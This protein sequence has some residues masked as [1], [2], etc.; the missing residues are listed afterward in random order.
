METI[1]YITSRSGIDHTYNAIAIRTGVI[2][3]P[4]TYAVGN[5]YIGI[6]YKMLS[7]RHYKT[8]AQ[9]IQFLETTP[10]FK[11]LKTTPAEMIKD[12]RDLWNQRRNTHAL[13][14]YKRHEHMINEMFNTTMTALQNAMR[15]T[16]LMELAPLRGGKELYV[17]GLDDPN[18]EQ[19]ERDFRISK[20]LSLKLDG[21]DTVGPYVF[22]LVDKLAKLSPEEEDALT[23]LI[24]LPNI[25]L[26]SLDQLLSVRKSLDHAA[27]QLQQL[28]VPDI[29]SSEKP[30]YA[31]G[32]WN[33]AMLTTCGKAIQQLIDGNPDLNWALSIQPSIRVHVLAGEMDI[34]RFWQ[35]QRTNNQM[36]DDTWE[37]LQALPPEEPYPRTVPVF[38]IKFSGLLPADEMIDQDVALTPKRKTISLD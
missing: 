9:K 12:M 32:H 4:A 36:P 37:V 7:E 26:L 38:V 24:T 2:I 14:Q 23:P 13:K 31:G 25:N 17:M 10:N 19:Y 34:Q 18:G 20:L 21:D 1:V 11:E 15:N 8:V 35:L 28:L 30:Q 16:R 6:L 33:K 5:A 22:T 3:S 27:K 29:S